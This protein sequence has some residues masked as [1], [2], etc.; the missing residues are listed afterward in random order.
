MQSRENSAF[1]KR[2]LRRHRE[3]HAWSMPNGGLFVSSG[4]TGWSSAP[5]APRFRHRA[6]RG[7]AVGAAAEL[8]AGAVDGSNG[9]LFVSTEG[10]WRSSGGRARRPP[11]ADPSSPMWC[12][13]AARGSG[14]TSCSAAP[15]VRSSQG[16]ILAVLSAGLASGTVVSSDG[17]ETICLWRQ[18][19]RGPDWLRH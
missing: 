15:P 6:D 1:A 9:G 18:R 19:C 13:V 5:T 7:N 10:P 11:P 3:R 14:S 8:I 12:S 4:G 2:S 17:T 16:L